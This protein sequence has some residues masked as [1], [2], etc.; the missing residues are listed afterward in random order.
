MIID[1]KMSDRKTKHLSGAYY[2]KR[3]NESDEE[4]E[5]LHLK[6]MKLDE[7]NPTAST[8][9]GLELFLDNKNEIEME[10]KKSD[11]KFE[12]CLKLCQKKGSVPK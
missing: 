9:I 7:G 1:L 3:K 12:I 8:S 2:L 5:K 10:E 4:K 6:F 11:G